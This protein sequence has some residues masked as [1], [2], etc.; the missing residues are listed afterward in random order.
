ME[1]DLA[2]KLFS[3]V[4]RIRVIE[5]EIAKRYPEQ[6]MRCPT[7]LSIGQEATPVALCATLKPEDYMV[8]AH[9]AHAHYMAKGGDVNA[10]IAELYG[11]KTGCSKGQ[12]GSMHLID[13]AV[14]FI[15]S[16]SIVAGTVPVGVG[17]A[18]AAKMRKEDRITVICI[19]DT[20]LEEG[21]FHE[22]MNF[23]SLHN[24]RVLFLC[25]NNF[26]SCFSDLSVR[27]PDRPLTDVAIAHKVPSAKFDGNRVYDMYQ[28]FEK[29]IPEMRANPG[30]Y[31]V[32]CQTYRYL[33][34]C[35]PYPDD[36]LEYR[37][38]EQVKFW[39]ENDPV[40]RSREALQEFGFW[41]Q[42]LEDKLMAEHQKT[43]DEA[44]EFALK[45]P[46]PELDEY[47]AY[48]YAE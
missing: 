11:K 15:G 47:G 32:E 5:E 13:L 6:E 37:D 21:V 28:G 1:K 30:P 46:Y 41:S 19:G 44:F 10:F 2:I 48:T 3:E 33:Q 45:S 4:L 22:S 43:A 34:H 23:A 27:Q 38:P 31:F 24:L 25:E 42:E 16:T 8:S 35:G 29:I 7:H 9:R 40:I 26:F 39:K 36:N 20:V 14:D 17:A 18:F 12:G